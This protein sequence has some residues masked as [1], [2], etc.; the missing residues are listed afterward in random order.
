[1]IPG[2]RSRSLQVRFCGAVGEVTGSGYLVETRS[3]RVLV[4]FGIFQG[5]DATDGKNRSLGRLDPRRLD[6]IV[7]TH[8]HLDHCGRLP[9]LFKA[10]CRAAVHTTP[11]SADFAQLVLEDAAHLQ[12]AD[13][14]RLNRRLERQRKPRIEPLYLPEDVR[15]VEG[16]FQGLPYGETPRGETGSGAKRGRS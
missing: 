11:A 14:Q 9:L 15:S 5:R 6:A 8:A 13:V 2:E 10:G 16:R 12:T 1:M 4:D 3:A 7:L